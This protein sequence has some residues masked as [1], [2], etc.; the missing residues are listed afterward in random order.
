MGLR[1]LKKRVADGNLVVLP[2]DKSGCFEVMSM[3]TY[4][5]AG[6]VH[7]K[8]DEEV[9]IEERRVNQKVVNGPVS[10]LLKVFRV[11]KECRHEGRW[12]E[13]MISNS[14]EACQQDQLW[15]E[16]EE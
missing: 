6:M 4:V 7:I 10:M 2:T 1:S 14:L 5:K 3:E 12:R 16:M 8:D 9:G 11:G 13:S 15:E